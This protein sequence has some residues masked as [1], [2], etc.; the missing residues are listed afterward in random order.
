MSSPFDKKKGGTATAT[1]ATAT[2]DAND[3]TA[4]PVTKIN[5]D[6]A[7][8]GDPFANVARPTGISGYKP[9]AFMGQLVLMHPTETGFMKT[10]SNTPENPQ[11]EYVRFDIIPLTE[12]QPGNP[13]RSPAVRDD[14]GNVV[15]LNK[16]GD[17]EVFDGYEVGERIDDV[18]VFNKP[19]V[20][21]G[22]NA[23]DKGNAWML[24]RIELG[25]KKVGQSPPVILVDGSEEDWALF[26]Q[27][28]AQRKAQR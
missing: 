17:P 18:L 20:R 21:E 6:A 12:P 14:E 24:G 9:I 16:D 5:G 13:T 22:K 3:P 15:V 28:R 7:P 27:W 11:S 8:K 26:E 2:A 4:A 23:L 25:Q 19:L 10:S 1:K